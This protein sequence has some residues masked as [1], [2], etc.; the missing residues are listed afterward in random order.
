MVHGMHPTSLQGTISMIHLSEPDMQKNLYQVGRVS[1]PA[2]G[3]VHLSGM[4][5][6]PTVASKMVA[7]R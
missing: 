6:R 2:I 4:E 3:M 1:Y 5:S 7:A